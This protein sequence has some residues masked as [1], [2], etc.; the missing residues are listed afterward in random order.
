MQ[1]G[2]RTCALKPFFCLSQREAETG[3]TQGLVA[4]AATAAAT[5]TVAATA[6]AIAATTVAATAAATTTTVAA[7][8]ATWR[9]CLHRTGFVDSDATTTQ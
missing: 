6:G 8:T 4:A 2:F 1:K 5:T 3:L 9:T 7:T